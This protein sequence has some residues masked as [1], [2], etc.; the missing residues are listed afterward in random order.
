VDP[1][2]ELL[3]AAREY[4][5][6]YANRKEWE[7]LAGKILDVVD[8]EEIIALRKEESKLINVRI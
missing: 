4:E 6:W 8:P 2:D 1:F 7:I 3:K 5:K